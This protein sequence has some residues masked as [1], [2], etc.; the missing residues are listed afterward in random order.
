MS[1]IE[2]KEFNFSFFSL[3]FFLTL[4]FFNIDSYKQTNIIEEDPTLVDP[5]LKV[6]K[7]AIETFSLDVNK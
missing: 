3:L 7:Y 6:G 2:C 4:I 1:I 5:S